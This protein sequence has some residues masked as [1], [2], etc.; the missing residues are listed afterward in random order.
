MERKSTQTGEWQARIT[1]VLF[2]RVCSCEIFLNKT[3]ERAT[4]DTRCGKGG[5]IFWTQRA[6]AANTELAGSRAA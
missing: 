3:P 1:I 6:A 5:N 2:D 4:L